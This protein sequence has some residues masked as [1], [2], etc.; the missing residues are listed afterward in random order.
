MEK[1]SH[2]WSRESLFA[3]AQLYAEAML[4]HQDTNWQFGLWSAFVLEMLIRA[5]IA[6]TSPALLADSKDWNDILY[7]LGKPSKKAKFVAKSAS[8]TDLIQ[9]IEDLSD[10]FT[11]EHSNFCAS[12]VARRNSEI[13][14][15][16]MPFENMGTS[17][18]LPMFY[19]VCEI[20]TS[21]IGE[22]LESLFGDETAERAKEEIAALKDDTAKSVRGTISAHR[23]VWSEKTDDEREQARK[24]AAT[25]ALRHYGHRVTC[26]ACESTA[27]LQ[28]K[29]AGEA[30]REVDD[31]R[32]CGKTSD[33]ARII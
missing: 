4:D 33:A 10:G 27:L 3:K 18:W 9:R 2:E 19:T 32:H 17:S 1:T 25:V 15:G 23:A 24:Q 5:A 30:R 14:S 21:E 8:I 13:H 7:A 28:G 16:S 20:L 12:H 29:A 31:E 22:S 11:R 26:P 6:D